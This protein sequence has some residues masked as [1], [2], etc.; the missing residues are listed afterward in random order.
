MPF[1]KMMRNKKNGDFFWFFGDIFYYKEIK[2]LCAKM[3]E[4]ILERWKDVS[5]KGVFSLI[6]L[7]TF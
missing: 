7:K 5:M 6:K 4:V 2:K 1:M 3:S